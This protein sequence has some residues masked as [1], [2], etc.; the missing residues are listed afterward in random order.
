MYW[1]TL[2]CIAELRLWW[3]HREK[4]AKE[5]LREVPA[6]SSSWLVSLVVS[7]GLNCPCWFTCGDCQVDWTAAADSCLVFSTELKLLIS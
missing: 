2:Y 3:R 7:S 1:F 6:A 4:F 5:L